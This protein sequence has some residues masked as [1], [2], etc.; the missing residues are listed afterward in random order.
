LLRSTQPS[1]FGLDVGAE[2]LVGRQTQTGRQ[3]VVCE[4]RELVRTLSARQPVVQVEEG[5]ALPTRVT[6][7]PRDREPTM[8][9]L[10]RNIRV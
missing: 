3:Q 5:G 9:T 4:K 7:D 2:E 10:R 6:G 1:L 8:R